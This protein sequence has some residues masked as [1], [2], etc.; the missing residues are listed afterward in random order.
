MY[1]LYMLA[2]NCIIT[3]RC[4]YSIVVISVFCV[5]YS[6]YSDSVYERDYI[7]YRSKQIGLFDLLSYY[8]TDICCPIIVTVIIF[9]IAESIHLS[10]KRYLVPASAL[11]Y[12]TLS[13]C[14][15]YLEYV[16]VVISLF[17]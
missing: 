6:L 15:Y 1:S 11:F 17:N 10:W 5:C 8:E 9:S 7:H 16:S 13:G 3:I 4:F 14:S 2:M 12:I